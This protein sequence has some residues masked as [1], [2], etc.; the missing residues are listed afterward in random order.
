M[1][2]THHPPVLDRKDLCPSV[3]QLR[4]TIGRTMTRR[5]TFG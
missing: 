1:P 4:N 3:F 2:P 5:K